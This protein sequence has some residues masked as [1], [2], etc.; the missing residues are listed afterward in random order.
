MAHEFGE[1]AL[2]FDPTASGNAWVKIQHNQRVIRRLE[3]KINQYAEAARVQGVRVRINSFT[4]LYSHSY[5]M[6]VSVNV[7]INIHFIMKDR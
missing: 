5:I 3:T 2:Y 1:N 6:L 7:V 4:V